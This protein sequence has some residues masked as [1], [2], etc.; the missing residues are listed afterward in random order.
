MSV[1]T[2]DNRAAY[3]PFMVLNPGETLPQAMDRHRRDTGHRGALIVVGWN[4]GAQPATRKHHAGEPAH[5]VA[6]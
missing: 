1:N 4:R 2:S 3:A 6:A 5:A